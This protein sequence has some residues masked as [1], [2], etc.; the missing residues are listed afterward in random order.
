MLLTVDLTDRSD[1]SCYPNRCELPK[2]FCYGDC[3]FKT[4]LSVS[5]L[6]K[7]KGSEFLWKYKEDQWIICL[8]TIYPHSWTCTCQTLD[9]YI[10]HC[11][12][13]F[14][15]CVSFQNLCLFWLD[16]ICSD[17]TFLLW[18]NIFECPTADFSMSGCLNIFF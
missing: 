4:D 13:K 18:F 10:H 2:H 5:V 12:N 16:T 7:V 15:Y 9:Y 14:G 1:I 11:L 3:S 8:D 6:E 17:V